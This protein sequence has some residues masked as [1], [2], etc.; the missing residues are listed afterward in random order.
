MTYDVSRQ[1]E[2]PKKK[3]D[4]L[5]QNFCINFHFVLI[6]M[7]IAVFSSFSHLLEYIFKH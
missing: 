4:A 6:M 5:L 3:L 7:L 1:Y 2:N